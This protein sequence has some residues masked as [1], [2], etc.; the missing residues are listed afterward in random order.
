[1]NQAKPVLKRLAPVLGVVVLLVALIDFGVLLVSHRLDKY[2]TH[3]RILV[4]DGAMGSLIQT[5][6][7]DEAGYRGERFK[8]HAY[9]VKGNNDLLNITQPDIIRE[10]HGKYLEA[11]ADILETNTFNAQAISQADYG[12]ED[13]SYEIVVADNGSDDRTY[14]NSRRCW[15]SGRGL[16]LCGS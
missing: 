8:D 2:L 5:Y 11:D 6:M 14:D 4:L 7:L 12:L 3:E 15:A 9:D 16:G 13:L 1:M 10:I